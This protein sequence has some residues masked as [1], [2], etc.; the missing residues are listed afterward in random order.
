[1][2]AFPGFSECW[3]IS[4]LHCPYCHGYE[5]RHQK[6]GI[7]ANGDSGFEFCS[8]IHNWTK[9]LI[10]F[11]NGQ[12]TLSGQQKDKLISHGIGIVEEEIERLEHK[13]GHIQTIQLKNQLPVPV[14]AFY[15]RLPFVQKSTV[16]Q[17]LGCEITE[18]GYIKI[19]GALKTTIPGVFACGDN[20]SRMR[21]V[22]NA[23]AM[24]TTAGFMVNKELIEEEF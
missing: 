8:L 18:E 11:T 6:T 22:S 3:G 17:S 9:D 5:V 1:M 10:L 15:C 12:S 19:D 23:V 13:N 4:V 16:P 21:T 2:P 20:S 24:G 7:L 14:D